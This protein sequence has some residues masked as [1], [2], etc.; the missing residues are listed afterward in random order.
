VLLA[1]GVVQIE[2]LKYYSSLSDKLTNNLRGLQIIISIVFLVFTLPLYINV[3][4]LG[5]VG[6]VWSNDLNPNS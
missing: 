1:A 6:S 3:L 2:I 5:N 4:Y